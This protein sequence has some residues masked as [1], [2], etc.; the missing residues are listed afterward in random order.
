MGGVGS[1]AFQRERPEL[2]EQQRVPPVVEWQ[3]AANASSACSPSRSFNSLAAASV[4]SG[5]GC[6]DT[7]SG[8]ALISSK[9]AESVLSNGRSVQ[10]TRIGSPSNRR[11]R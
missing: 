9:A 2:M 8:S 7:L 5:L 11:T 1:D 3:A 4:L 6:S 10:T